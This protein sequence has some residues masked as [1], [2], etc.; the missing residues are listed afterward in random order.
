MMKTLSKMGTDGT[1]LYIIKPTYDKLT[2]NIIINGETERPPT[3]F[4]K[5]SLLYKYVLEVLATTIRQEK[6]IKGI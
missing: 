3:E 1:Y 5:R 4:W 2:E 6:E